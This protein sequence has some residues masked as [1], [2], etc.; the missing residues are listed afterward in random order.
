M[1]NKTIDI[2][3][4][5]A[6]AE[7]YYRD[8]DFY[9]SE[10]LLKCIKDAFEA[11]FS[12][13]VIKLASGFPIGMGAGCT[14]GAVNAGVMALGMFFGRNKAK[15]EEV[16]KAMELTKELQEVF[17]KSRKVC[18]CKILTKGLDFGSEKHLSHCIGITGEVTAMTG[19]I[20]AREL[21]YTIVD[22]A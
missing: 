4:I 3:E 15:G 18:C 17:T 7:K 11:P 16:A 13:D 5:Q 22:K 20:L 21:G 1:S 10:A 12:D 9:C 2:Q 19:R 6:I 14:C 8:G